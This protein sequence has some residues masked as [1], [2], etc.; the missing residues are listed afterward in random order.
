MI[1]NLSDL[2][3]NIKLDKRSIYL[4]K[5]IVEAIAGGKR[6]HLGSATSVLELIR[7]LYDEFLNID[8]NDT[9]NLN[10]DRFI[11]S[12]GHGCLALYAVL[13]DK[14]FFDLNKLKTFC[15]FDS[16]LGGHPEYGKIN[17][18]E[19]S[20]GSLGH[21]MSIGVGM[22]IASKISGRNNRVVVLVGDGEIN[23]GSCWEAAMSA[24]KHNLA[25][26]VVM[27]DY[28]KIQS[29]GLTKEVLDLSP[30]KDKFISFGFSLKEIN[31]HDIVEIS[32]TLK[33][34]PFEK[35]KPSLILCHTVKGKGFVF[36][37]NQPSW[38]HKSKLTEIEIRKLFESVK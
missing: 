24:S 2:S 11:L 23:E 4:R 34:I 15:K 1:Y 14:N 30:I 22:A 13:A 32:E 10:R 16:I 26:L 25:N 18:I 9:K 27:V 12:K 7:V 19:A 29:Y 21:G 28:N 37:E 8:K 31:G 17:G 35:N 3:N 20:T 33:T 6:A 38:H 36:T 5:L